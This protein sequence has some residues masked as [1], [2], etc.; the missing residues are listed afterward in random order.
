MHRF[1]NSASGTWAG[2]DG[3]IAR[4]QHEEQGRLRPL[5]PEDDRGGVWGLD[6]FDVLVPEL[7]GV[8]FELGLG[9]G[10]PSD[11]VEGVLHVLRR[12]GVA[13]VPLHV[14][15]EE[16]DEVPVVVLP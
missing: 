9:V 15:A 10:R 3:R 13:I 2:V 1:L 5:E 4:G 16:E 14:T 7:P 11:H 6:R 12:E 8:H